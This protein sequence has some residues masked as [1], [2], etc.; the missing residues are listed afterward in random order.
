MSEAKSGAMLEET[1]LGYRFV[2][3]GYDTVLAR[4]ALAAL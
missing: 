2:H 1:D 3:P 4:F